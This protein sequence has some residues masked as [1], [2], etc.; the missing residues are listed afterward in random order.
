MDPVQQK[1]IEDQSSAR[2]VAAKRAP[3]RKNKKKKIHGTKRRYEQAKTII[4]R[5]ISVL[6]A[7]RPQALGP[8]GLREKK[9]IEHLQLKEGKWA[10]EKNKLGLGGAKKL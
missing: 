9:K 4:S 7:K 1:V 2:E 10:E 8:R 3:R 5:G 6:K